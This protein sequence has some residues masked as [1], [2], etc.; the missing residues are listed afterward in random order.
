MGL[1]TLDVAQIH[2]DALLS[3]APRKDPDP[4]IDGSRAALARVCFTDVIAPNESTHRGALDA[5]RRIGALARSLR[6]KEL[7]LGATRRELRKEHA[8]REAAELALATSEAKTHGLL[9][10]SNRMQDELRHLARQTL[11]MQEEERKE[12][13]RELHDEIAQ[14]LTAI[15]VHLAALMK[16]ASLDAN[17][18]R[19][20]I[21]RTQRL[22]EKSVGVVH[23]FARDLRPTML[24][25]L[26]LIPALHW[27]M[28]TF[29][30]RTKIPIRFS[31]FAGVERLGIEKRTAL[32]RVAQEA[33]TN[34]ARHAHA[35]RVTVSIERHQG[36]VSMEVADNGISFDVGEPSSARKSKRLGLIGMRERV[37]M[38]GGTLAIDSTPGK[39]TTIA[40]RIPSRGSR[41]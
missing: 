1:D 6:D 24:D 18:V 32:Y 22:V 3:L 28:K 12:I 21:A 40:A 39:G 25:N 38:V 19:R 30:A 17:G 41:P 4:E 37:E 2:E 16:A 7:E 15:N 35:T 5:E 36:A 29:T 27:F 20:R 8:R 9:A 34:V 23:K 33:L 26:G 11:S 13:S 10:D 14:T 31:A